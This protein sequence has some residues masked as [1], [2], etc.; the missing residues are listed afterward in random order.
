VSLEE[1]KAIVRKVTEAENNRDLA[2]IEKLISPTFFNQSLQLQGPEGYRQFLAMLFKAFPN[3]H[4]TIEDTIAE[5]DKVC[6]HLKIDTGPHTG[7]FNFLGITVSPTGEKSTV[8]SIQIWR[9]ADGKV[10]EQESVVDEL[11]LFKQMGL[12]VPTE[13][14]KKL[15]PQDVS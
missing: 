15:F 8:K 2:V 11:D 5:G 3:W 7:E 9:T 13:K 14:G 1:D 10:E 4:E 6:V 12:I